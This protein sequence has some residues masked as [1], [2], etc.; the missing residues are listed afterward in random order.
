VSEPTEPVRVSAAAKREL[1]LLLAELRQKP[2]HGRLTLGGVVEV[3]LAER[4]AAGGARF[5]SSSPR[6]RQGGVI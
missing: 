6:R 5:R 4:K 2:G 1:E 3:L